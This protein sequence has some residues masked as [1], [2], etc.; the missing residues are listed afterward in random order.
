MLTEMNR[1]GL[2]S[3]CHG[4]KGL[5]GSA[6]RAIRR[7]FA[8]ALDA[9]GVGDPVPLPVW[10]QALRSSAVMTAAAIACHPVFRRNM[11]LSLPRKK[12]VENVRVESA[13]ASPP[14]ALAPVARADRIILGSPASHPPIPRISAA[15]S[16]LNPGRKVG[17]EEV[18]L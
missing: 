12:A 5:N 8:P 11:N 17:S 18:R 2:S 9:P 6:L 10:V 3:I 14:R 16:P 13:T 4:T 7:T 1:V 15:C